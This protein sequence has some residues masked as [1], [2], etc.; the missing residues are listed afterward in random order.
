MIIG[1]IEK[2]EKTIKFSIELN[3]SNCAKK[4]PGSMKASE[5]FFNSKEFPAKI[6]SFRKDYLCGIC[7]DKKRT[8]K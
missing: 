6:K 2:N 7:R 5:K 1:N 3:C 4:V 8:S